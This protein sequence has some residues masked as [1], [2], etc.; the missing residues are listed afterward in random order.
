M[1]NLE[2]A[3]D[4][5][6]NPVWAEICEELN[7]KIFHLSEKLYTCSPEVLKDIQTEI[8]VYQAVKRLPQDI[9]SREENP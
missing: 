1:M 7:K 4:L 9:I 5:E 6:S 8:K 2:R 3:K